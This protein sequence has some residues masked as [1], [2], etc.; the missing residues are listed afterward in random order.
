VVPKLETKVLPVYPVETPKQREDHDVVMDV[1]LNDD[2]SVQKVNVIEGDP[3]LNNAATD[4]VKQW[5]YRPLT[6]NGKL[7][8]QFVVVLTFDKNG[9]VR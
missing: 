9:K 8:K 3:V 7:V 2:G 5:R 6:V 1:T 4:A